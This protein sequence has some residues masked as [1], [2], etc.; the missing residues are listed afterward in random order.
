VS[1][2]YWRIIDTGAGAMVGLVLVG[3][4]WDFTLT[5]FAYPDSLTGAVTSFLLLGIYEL[6]DRKSLK[7]RDRVGVQTSKKGGWGL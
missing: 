5:L 2:F 3:K 4:L 7:L 1:F 6:R